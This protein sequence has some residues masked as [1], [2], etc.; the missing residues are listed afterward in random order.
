VGILDLSND[1]I[2]RLSELLR[3]EIKAYEKSNKYINGLS[4]DKHSRNKIVFVKHIPGEI[5]D[6]HQK[7]YFVSPHAL[8]Q[9][10]SSYL[11]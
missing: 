5:K 8:C 11:V 1:E 7:A 4:P 6:R 3:D 10:N 2:T 9:I